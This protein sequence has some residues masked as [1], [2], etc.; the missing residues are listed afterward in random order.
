MEGLPLQRVLRTT[1]LLGPPARDKGYEQAAD[2]HR[3]RDLHGGDI[4][5][6]RQRGI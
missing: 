1:L 2:D 4:G 3:G 6:V 5:N